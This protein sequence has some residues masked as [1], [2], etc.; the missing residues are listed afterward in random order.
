[1]RLTRVHGCKRA[2]E[3]GRVGV[4]RH[5][6]ASQ[7]RWSWALCAQGM[8]SAGRHCGRRRGS[9]RKDGWRECAA[10]GQWVKSTHPSATPALPWAPSAP[11]YPT[12][13]SL[14]SCREPP[15]PAPARSLLGPRCPGT[16]AGGP[17][18]C[19]ETSPSRLGHKALGDLSKSPVPNMRPCGFLDEGLRNGLTPPVFPGYEG[20]EGRV[21]LALHGTGAGVPREQD[22]T[23]P[24]CASGTER[25]QP[26][27]E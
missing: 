18:V 10:W 12:Q 11:V 17:H 14:A 25:R 19:V 24:W 3:P 6:C 15:T 8:T 27:T 21:V 13:Q 26:G 2:W 1:M 22:A 16:A 23:L 5:C 7:E 20:H 4:G 9:G